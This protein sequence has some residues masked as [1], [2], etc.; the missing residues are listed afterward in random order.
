MLNKIKNLVFNYSLKLTIVFLISFNLISCKKNYSLEY[1]KELTKKYDTLNNE[2]IKNYWIRY[3]SPEIVALGYDSCGVGIK[4][5][6]N[7]DSL[8]ALSFCTSI[9]FNK[10]N[11]IVNNFKLLNV[12]ALRVDSIGNISINP[13]NFEKQFIFRIKHYNETIYKKLRG[14]WYIDMELYNIYYK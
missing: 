6:P 13:I 11:E 14:D 4:I 10:V 1:F 8:T 2:N 3:R 7:I 9:N 12:G 5:N